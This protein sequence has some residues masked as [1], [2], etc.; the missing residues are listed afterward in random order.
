M[1]KL[2]FLAVSLFVL[3]T[4]F[5][6]DTTLR[7]PVTRT[8]KAPA[9]GD[10]LMIQL[11]YTFWNGKPDT[12][13]TKGFSR[14]FNFYIMFAF[15][16]KTN[17]KLSVALGPGLATDHI[18]FDRMDVR[19]RDNSST[20]VFDNVSDTNYF[21]KYKLATS[22]L[23]V[24]VELRFSSNPYNDGK[25]FK[26]ALGA[27]VATLLSAWTKGSDLA[28]KSGNT[29][30]EFI[31]KEKSKRFFNGTRISLMGRIGIGH[32][33]LFGT[34]ALSPLLEDGV[35]PVLKPVTIGLTLSGL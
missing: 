25:S 7:R 10:H 19:I 15:P 4:S 1:R 35:G 17:P 34:Y 29:I 18:F 14:S 8:Q 5:A 31:E 16:F 2:I 12:I 11:G 32:F 33:T 21:K 13:N 20:L 6:Q 22:Y 26:V 24:P 30:N 28:N 23:E 27:K 3:Q 9:T